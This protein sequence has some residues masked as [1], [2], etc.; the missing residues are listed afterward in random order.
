MCDADSPLGREMLTEEPGPWFPWDRL[1][2]VSELLEGIAAQQ[3]R[4]L[5]W[6]QKALRRGDYHD[7]DRIIGHFAAA[8]R[9]IADAGRVDATLFPGD[10]VR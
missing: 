5:T 10:I 2:A 9:A 4:F 3:E 1:D 6:R 7:R 8:I